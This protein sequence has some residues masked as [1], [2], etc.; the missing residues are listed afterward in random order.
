MLLTIPGLARIDVSR[1]ALLGAVALLLPRGDLTAQEG[2]GDYRD[3]PVL[4]DL[5]AFDREQSEM[6]AALVRYDEDR[7]A[8]MRRYDIPLSPVR[9]DR[10]RTFYRGW[11]G[12]LEAMDFDALNHE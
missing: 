3:P 1:L 11:L 9:R 6:R 10:L 4:D 5:A 12:A 2:P 8:L 7:D